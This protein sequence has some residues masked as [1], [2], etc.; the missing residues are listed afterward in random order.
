MSERRCRRRISDVDLPRFCAIGLQAR[1]D[2]NRPGETPPCPVRRIL[3]H[4][5]AMMRISG[6][7][8]FPDHLQARACRNM[9]RG[10]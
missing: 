9:R 5:S 3:H 4:A 2:H 6:K 7:C 1:G 8:L 10:G